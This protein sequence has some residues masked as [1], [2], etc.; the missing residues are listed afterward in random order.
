MG[1]LGVAAA[2]TVAIDH[3]ERTRELVEIGMEIIVRSTCAGNQYQWPSV[4]D[5]FV[6]DLFAQ[7]VEILSVRMLYFLFCLGHQR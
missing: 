3:A 7:D 6:P 5:A 2:E 4:T 1:V